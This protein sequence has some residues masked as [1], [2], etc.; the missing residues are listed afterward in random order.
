MPETF[1]KYGLLLLE[2]PGKIRPVQ[3]ADGLARAAGVPHLDAITQLRLPYSFIL[4]FL[5]EAHAKDAASFLVSNGVAAVA[6]PVSALDVA[7][8]S[9]FIRNADPKPEGLLVQNIDKH[10]ETLLP[11][12]VLRA[13]LAAH[14]LPAASQPLVMPTA[15]TPFQ[16]NYP[17]DVVD[18]FTGTTSGGCPSLIG[19]LLTGGVWG[20]LGQILAEASAGT[21]VFP[22][23][24]SRGTA[25][26]ARVVEQAAVSQ[27][28][29]NTGIEDDVLFLIMGENPVVISVIDR[30]GFNY[31]YLGERLATSTRLNF[32]SLA[33]DL[34]RFGHPLYVNRGVLELIRDRKM[35]TENV[36]GKLVSRWVLER[37]LALSLYE[38]GLVPPEVTAAIGN[39]E[40]LLIYLE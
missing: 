22:E 40:S 23:D 37:V 19:S 30:G 14:R 2:K 35:P 8:G 38:K 10:E 31:D 20:V 6:Q 4:P 21:S 29:L 36:A 25:L 15:S 34:C 24:T 33:Q 39:D 28:R 16:R 32:Q 9:G 27:N 12:K 18:W 13:V 7:H 5:D 3:I 26:Q 11:W 17:V 1:E